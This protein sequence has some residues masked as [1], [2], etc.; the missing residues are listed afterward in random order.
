MEAYD[1]L[2]SS[3]YTIGRL[4]PEGVDFKPYSIWDDHFRMGNYI[5]AQMDD[6]LTQRLARFA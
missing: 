3:G 4:Y 6:P 1:L 5:A 2:R